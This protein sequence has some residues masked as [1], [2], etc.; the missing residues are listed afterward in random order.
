MLLNH[1]MVE[2]KAK[3]ERRALTP[4]ERAEA[5]RLKS[6]YEQKKHQL[7]LTQEKLAHLMGFQTQGAVSQYFNR[8]PMSAETVIRFAHFLNVEPTEIRPNIWEQ[9]PSLPP[10]DLDR[11]ASDFA[12]EYASAPDEDRQILRQTLDILKRRR[13]T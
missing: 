9:I 1:S 3:H 2:T 8:L 7:G 5:A 11:D 6:I 13:Q 10:G 4:E 12:R